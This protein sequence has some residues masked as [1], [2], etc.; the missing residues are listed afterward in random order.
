MS[1]KAQRPPKGEAWTW[2]TLE[3]R[4]SDA[5]RAAGI[6]ARRFVDFLLLEHMRHGGKANGKL[7]APHRHLTCLSCRTADGLLS[8]VH[9]IVLQL[10]PV[11]ANP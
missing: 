8:A 3:L 1:S 6:N 9:L 4:S 11:V 2:Q 10:L 7:K 5:W